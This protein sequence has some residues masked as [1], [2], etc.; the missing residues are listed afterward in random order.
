MA[1]PHSPEATAPVEFDAQ[2]DLSL[3]AEGYGPIEKISFAPYN[4][5]ATLQKAVEC[6]RECTGHYPERG[7]RRLDLPDP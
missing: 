5:G 6:F 4:E 3:D 7:P 1:A 2:F